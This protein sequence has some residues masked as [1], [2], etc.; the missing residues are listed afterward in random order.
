MAPW[1]RPAEAAVRRPPSSST[2]ARLTV[3]PSPRPPKRRVMR[4][5]AC[6][7]A[8]KTRGSIS[9]SMPMPVSETSTTS[10]RGAPSSISERTVMVPPSGVN[11]T[12]L[13]KRFQNTWVRR[14]P[15]AHTR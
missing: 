11:L 14:G 5:S 9:G 2:I 13:F 1:P 6:S 8:S 10:C 3:S 4:R 15:S 12:A 7:K